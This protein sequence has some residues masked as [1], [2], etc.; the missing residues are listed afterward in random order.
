MQLSMYFSRIPGQ[1]NKRQKR[2][3]EPSPKRSIIDNCFRHVSMA[4]PS[5]E[6]YVEYNYICM[7]KLRFLIQAILCFLKD[8]LLSIVLFGRV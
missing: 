2:P 5:S 3:S 7:K 8:I 1:Y 6:F 4:P